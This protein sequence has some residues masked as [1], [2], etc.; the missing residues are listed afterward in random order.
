MAP[1]LLGISRFHP[2]KWIKFIALAVLFAVTAYV[3]FVPR[4]SHFGVEMER[5]A[6]RRAATLVSDGRAVLARF[7]SEEDRARAAAAFQRALPEATRASLPQEA[8]DDAFD[9]LFEFTAA[10][11]A[12]T[13]EEYIDWAQSRGHR[14]RREWPQNAPRDEAVL[15]QIHQELVGGA[16]PDP[17]TPERFFEDMFRLRTE[18]DGGA[19]RPVAMLTGAQV[20]QVDSLTFTHP[21]D[22][23]DYSWPTGANELGVEFW[24]GGS[25][26]TGVRVWDPPRTLEEII[27]ADGEAPAMRV[28]YVAQ[29]AGGDHLIFV[30]E[31]VYDPSLKQWH[32]HRIMQNNTLRI[33]PDRFPFPVY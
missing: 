9:T 16:P 19:A 27:A 2:P 15:R 29:T 25:S 8:L 14:L 31:L 26:G 33:M 1:A 18:L 12:E 7:D 17:L 10:L 21:A 28:H 11:G 32:V 24:Y 5:E 13:P 3:L 6:Q 4:H 23:F 22:T 20:F 30:V